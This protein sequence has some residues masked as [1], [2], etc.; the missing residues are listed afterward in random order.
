MCLGIPMQIIEISGHNARCESNGI[1]REVSL[2]LMQDTLPTI[3]D[4]VVVHIGYAI[5]H[6]D[7]DL[8]IAAQTSFNEMTSTHA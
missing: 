6:V 7:T 3:G 8:A 1:F 2:F 4:Y 5:Q